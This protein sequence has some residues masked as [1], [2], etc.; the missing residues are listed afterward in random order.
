MRQL[1]DAEIYF[2]HPALDEEQSLGSKVE[3]GPIYK[4][5]IMFTHPARSAT[6]Q[7]QPTIW[8]GGCPLQPKGLHDM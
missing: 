8:W 6:E 4:A 5:Q 2:T 1:N 3:Y 7:I